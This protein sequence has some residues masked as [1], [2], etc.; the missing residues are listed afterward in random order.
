MPKLKAQIEKEKREQAV[1]LAVARCQVMSKLPYDMQVA[2]L[3]GI[4]R[5]TYCRYKR[6]KFQRMPK[7]LF[8]YMARLLG[9]TDKEICECSGIAYHGVT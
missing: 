8:D 5:S 7:E 2:D 6:D 4:S 3:I 1:M 9:F